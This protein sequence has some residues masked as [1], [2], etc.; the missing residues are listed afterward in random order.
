MGRDFG[1]GLIISQV[2]CCDF[3]GLDFCAAFWR[4]A[5]QRGQWCCSCADSWVC[6]SKEDAAVAE[7]GQRGVPF[8]GIGGRRHVQPVRAQAQ[9]R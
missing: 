1:S 8:V 2:I 6:Q 4:A 5:F 9:R 3:M 7:P